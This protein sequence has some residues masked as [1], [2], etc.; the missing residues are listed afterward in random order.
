M[1]GLN[2]LNAHE[3]AQ[4]IRD[5]EITSEALVQDCL[6]RIADSEQQVHAWQYL[7]NAAAL[8]QARTRDTTPVRGLLHGVPVGI[9]DLI[10][11]GDMPTCY[12]SSIYAG[13]RPASD[14]E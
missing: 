14:A 7:D 6:D 8:D 10:N 5:H 12:G 2:E 9:K 3:A 1:S 4:K 11:T 13:H